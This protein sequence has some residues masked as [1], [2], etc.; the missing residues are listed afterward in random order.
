MAQ[1][2]DDSKYLWQATV[3]DSHTRIGLNDLARGEIGEISF[4]AFPK[5]LSAVA[6]GDVILSFEGAKAVTEVHSPKAGKVA[7]IN[8]ALI[9]HPEYLD[10]S[11]QDKNWIVELY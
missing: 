4:A 3:D 11:D 2:I 10:D 8:T 7:K 9:D 1:K 6:E 5:N